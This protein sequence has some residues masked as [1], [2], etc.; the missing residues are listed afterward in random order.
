MSEEYQS[1]LDDLA[2][3]CNN[4]A[5]V[6]KEKVS[7]LIEELTKSIKQAQEELEFNDEFREVFEE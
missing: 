2:E 3:A 5:E 6:F 4:F 1:K 7:P